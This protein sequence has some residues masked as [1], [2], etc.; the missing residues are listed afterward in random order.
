MKKTFVKRVIC[1]VALVALA[2][3]VIFAAP[4]KQAKPKP[5]KYEK[6]LTKGDPVDNIKKLTNTLKKKPTDQDAADILDQLVK[7]T[8]NS[9]LDVIAPEP[10][11]VV[12]VI[13][14]YMKAGSAMEALQKVKASITDGSLVWDDPRT[15]VVLD[16]LKKM[17]YR[18]N[19][20]YLMLSYV[21]TLPE[22]IGA[23]PTYN[24]KEYQVIKA[25]YPFIKDKQ[26]SF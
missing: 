26:Q 12:A 1:C 18:A 5:N 23:D 3:G 22:T 4:A 24:T 10:N 11:D 7:Q 8:Q 17:E 2:S 13:T 16:E 21:E 9:L 20:W 6:M 15:K 14:N 25:G 19:D